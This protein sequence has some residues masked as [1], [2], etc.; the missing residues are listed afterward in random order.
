MFVCLFLTTVVWRVANWK[1][2]S[3]EILIHDYNFFSEYLEV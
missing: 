3:N 2:N 1:K